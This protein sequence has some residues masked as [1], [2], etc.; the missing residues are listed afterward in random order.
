MRLVG[1]VLPRMTASL[2]EADQAGGPV[3]RW[4]FLSDLPSQ[5]GVE[6]QSYSPR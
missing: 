3:Y 1:P 6:L 2:E 4:I 5:L